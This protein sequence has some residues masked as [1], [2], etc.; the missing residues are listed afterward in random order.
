MLRTNEARF[1]WNIDYASLTEPDF[2]GDA[3]QPPKTTPTNA[4]HGPPVDLSNCSAVTIQGEHALSKNLMEI[5]FKVIRPKRALLMRYK[6][7]S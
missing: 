2:S 7:Y 3:N 5:L 6:S 4:E 1:R